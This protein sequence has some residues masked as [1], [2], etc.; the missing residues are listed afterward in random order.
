MQTSKSEQQAV[1]EIATLLEAGCIAMAFQE[2]MHTVIGHIASAP[3]LVSLSTVL[4]FGR[5]TQGWMS[6]DMVDSLSQMDIAAAAAAATATRLSQPTS[7]E[8]FLI[9]AANGVLTLNTNEAVGLVRRVNQTKSTIP[10]LSGMTEISEAIMETLIAC[11]H[12]AR[13]AG[14]SGA[15]LDADAILIRYM[16]KP[17]SRESNVAPHLEAERVL[18]RAF[19]IPAGKF[20]D[21]VIN[22]HR[23]ELIRCLTF[24]AYELCHRDGLV[25]AEARRRFDELK[26]Q[27]QNM[28]ARQKPRLGP[29]T[30]TDAMTD[31]ERSLYS[32]AVETLKT[33]KVTAPPRLSGRVFLAAA[34]LISDRGTPLDDLSGIRQ[35]PER[36]TT[37]IN[38]F[39]RKF[40]DAAPSLSVDGLI[41][42][43]INR[44]TPSLSLRDALLRALHAN[45]EGQIISGDIVCFA[46]A[47]GDRSDGPLSMYMNQEALKLC[48]ALRSAGITI[49]TGLSHSGD[50]LAFEGAS[51]GIMAT[52]TELASVARSLLLKNQCEDTAM[53]R[54]QSTRRAAVAKA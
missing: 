43:Y 31:A 47:A 2:R 12:L 44:D 40:E 4:S 32:V 5:V 46:R 30:M 53:L 11:R 10:A 19:G 15:V 29:T 21:S 51:D 22:A 39:L 33:A 34:P 27:S 28:A 37:A 24:T 52:P 9:D 6:A 48:G 13:L 42:I 54:L 14:D 17:N 1:I 26:V 23:A 20:H 16:D 25:H 7:H 3:Q 45:G 41:P 38:D 36:G 35:I 50:R 8:S 49:L 18:C